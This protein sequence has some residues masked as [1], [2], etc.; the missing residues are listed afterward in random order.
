MALD[1]LSPHQRLEHK[2]DPGS[3]EY[4]VPL[5]LP[6]PLD[7]DDAKH[8]TNEGSEMSPALSSSEF[9]YLSPLSSRTLFAAFY[10]TSEAA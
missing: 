5:P 7:A 1:M 2:V 6:G 3:N 4:V 9:P 8:K 10:L